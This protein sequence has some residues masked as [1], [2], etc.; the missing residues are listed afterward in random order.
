MKER[1]ETGEDRRFKIA[2]RRL[3]WRSPFSRAARMSRLS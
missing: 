2:V 1:L 3:S